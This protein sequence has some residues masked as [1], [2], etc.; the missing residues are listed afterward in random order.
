L[1]IYDFQ[2]VKI[3]DFD[4]FPSTSKIPQKIKDFF[5]TQII[6][7]LALILGLQKLSVFDNLQKSLIF[8]VRKI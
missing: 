4:S 3:I 5:G 7:L 6:D 1:K 8:G 2:R